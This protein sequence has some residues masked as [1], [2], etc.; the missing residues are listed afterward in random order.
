MA[1]KPMTLQEV[2]QAHEQTVLDSLNERGLNMMMTV[3]FP[4]KGKVPLLGRLGVW[5][6]NKAGGNIGIKYF[7]DSGTMVKKKYR[8]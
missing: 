2:V 7:I 5:L 8:Q 6:V 4:G 1:K 3:Q